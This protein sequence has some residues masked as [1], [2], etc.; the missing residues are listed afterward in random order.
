METT[1]TAQ[2]FM[3]GRSQAVRL[4]KLF[5]FEGKE[6]HI[7]KVGNSVVLTPVLVDRWSAFEEALMAFDFE[8]GFVLERPAPMPQSPREDLFR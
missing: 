6:V 8:P 5:R 2:L 3:N 4:P 1:E 7:K